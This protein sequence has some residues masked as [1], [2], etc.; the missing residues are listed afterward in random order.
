MES[1][2]YV[3]DFESRNLRNQG[4]RFWIL[5]QITRLVAREMRLDESFKNQRFTFS[6]VPCASSYGHFIARKEFRSQ[7]HIL[8]L[9]RQHFGITILI[10]ILIEI[11]T[12]W[13]W[14]A[15]GREQVTKADQIHVQGKPIK[16]II[17]SRN[18]PAW[19]H[20]ASRGKNAYGRGLVFFNRL[21]FGAWVPGGSPLLIGLP[22]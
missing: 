5:L 7:C 6:K 20:K 11:L 9:Y 2:M 22:H 19:R 17:K 13:A 18:A 16:K 3:N 8:R 1:F 4:L 12:F 21:T 10:K 14:K 15:Q